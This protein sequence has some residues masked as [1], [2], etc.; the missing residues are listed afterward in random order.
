[1]DCNNYVSRTKMLAVVRER[2][3]ALLPYVHVCY[4]GVADMYVGQSVV[5]AKAGVH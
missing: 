3:S 2:C 1:M 5:M 4:G